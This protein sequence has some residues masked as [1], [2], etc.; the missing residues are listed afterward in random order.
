MSGI[1]DALQGIDF[2]RILAH[3]FPGF[4]LYVAILMAMDSFLLTSPILSTTITSIIIEPGENFEALTTLIIIG[5]FVGSILGIMIDGI[6]HWLL[7]HTLFRN[8]VR[9]EL[10][11]VKLGNRLAGLENS[12][13][14]VGQM[15]DD[16]FYAWMVDLNI[17]KRIPDEGKVLSPDYLYGYIADKDGNV[18]LKDKLISDFY[19]YY[20]FYINS[21]ISLILISLVAP[22]YTNIV[23]NIPRNFSLVTMA[24]G[25]FFSFLLF[26]AS[27]HTLNH[28]KQARYEMIEGFLRKGED[29][30]S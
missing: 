28:Y 16:T 26:L 19:S 22:F 18:G 9:S 21:S 4:L 29:P 14:T 24:V 8:I 13:R 30:E 7:E 11:D 20:E 5:L 1:F 27:I 2:K 6:N 12:K 10:L 15:E 17:N 23:L 25:L 3:V